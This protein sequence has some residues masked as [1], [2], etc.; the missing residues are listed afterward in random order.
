MNWLSLLLPF[1]Y[2]S[3]LVLSLATFSHLYRRRKALAATRLK[4]WFPQHITR[5]IYLT[6]LEQASTASSSSTKSGLSTSSPRKIP[7][8]VLRAALLRRATTDIHRLIQV[9]NA[10]PAL[11]QL[12]QRGAVGDEL[13]QR[14]QIAEK[15]IQDEL[16]DVV[17]EANALGP[18]WGQTIFQSAGECAHAE[19]LR[20][21]LTEI[22]A[23]R[24]S[25]REEWERRR[26]LMRGEFLREIG[27]DKVDPNGRATPAAP[28]NSKGSAIERKPRSSDED[29]VLVDGG[30][31]TAASAG[32]EAEAV[33]PGPGGSSSKKKK[34]KK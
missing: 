32:G 12:L 29:A 13:W 15:E 11:A 34:G 20:K 25:E 21:S 24:A 5:Q 6:L 19:Q 8:S 16:R 28:G 18:N 9:R 30:G 23:E 14:F 26:D 31:P 33:G 27:D 7:D 3:V 1:G 4:P 2:L 10:K 22:E 17:G